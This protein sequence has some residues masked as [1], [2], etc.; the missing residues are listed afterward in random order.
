MAAYTVLEVDWHDEK[1]AAEY[2]ELLGPAVEKYGGRTLV[3]NTPIPLEGDWHPPRVIIMEFP[4]MTALQDWYKSA[5]HEPAL[6]IRKAAATSRLIA[7]EP[8]ARR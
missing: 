2:R 5:E 3:A 1:K 4:S 8:P 6:R 7:V